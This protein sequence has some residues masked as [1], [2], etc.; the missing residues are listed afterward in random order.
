MSCFKDKAIDN[1]QNFDSSISVIITNLW[2]LMVIPQKEIYFHP[3][4]TETVTFG[5]SF[6]NSSR[7]INFVSVD[8]SGS[9]YLQHPNANTAYIKLTSTE[10]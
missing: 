3:S 7:P 4:H 6:T 2:I 10:L 8:V 1:I 5:E 9:I